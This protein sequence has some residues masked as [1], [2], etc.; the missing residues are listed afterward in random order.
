[1]KIQQLVLPNVLSCLLL[2]STLE[3]SSLAA[4]YLKLPPS[5]SSNSDPFDATGSGRD[6]RLHIFTVDYEYVQIPCEVTLWILLACLAK[7][8]E[9]TNI[10]GIVLLKSIF[11]CKGN[12]D[13]G[14]KVEVAI[15]QMSN[16][17]NLLWII[18]GA[19]TG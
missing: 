19:T 12:C 14:R 11:P 15:K 8:G 5:N 16:G 9:Y 13:N 2:L 18:T 7:I 4:G 3:G 1:M 17:D 6:E 10:L